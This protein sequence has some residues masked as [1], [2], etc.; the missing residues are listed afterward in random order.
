MADG[1]LNPAEGAG[2]GTLLVAV[3]VAG[4]WA[5]DVWL[6]ARRTPLQKASDAAALD[7]QSVATASELMK[8]MREDLDALR[9]VVAGQAEKIAALDDAHAECEQRCTALTGEVRNLQ[10]AKKAQARE[11]AR[12]RERLKDPAATN[13][14]GVVEGAIFEL[15][16]GGI[17]DVSGRPLIDK[18][19]P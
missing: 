5:V 18:D 14:G 2:V 4:K 3:G 15:A 6:K 9:G 10:H 1:G 13:P 11:F 8:G 17:Q 7:K 16:E 19:K 12:L